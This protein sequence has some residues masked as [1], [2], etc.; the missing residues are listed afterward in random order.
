[1]ILL[2]LHSFFDGRK[3]RACI[4]ILV[5]PKDWAHDHEPSPSPLP[6]HFWSP[7][8]PLCPLLSPFCYQS[9]LPPPSY[10]TSPRFERLH[11]ANTLHIFNIN[12]PHSH[13]RTI[14]QRIDKIQWQNDCRIGFA[15][16]VIL[17]V[18]FKILQMGID[19]SLF[20]WPLHS[21]RF[22]AVSRLSPSLLPFA[23]ELPLFQ[24]IPYS[25]VM[26]ELMTYEHQQKQEPY[27]I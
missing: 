20:H 26:V 13:F 15:Y 3:C 9:P 1:M 21:I 2:P 18:S 8:F 17:F 6:L 4:H 27:W 16:T 10:P 25:T 22:F 12:I 7:I 23:T 14:L 24:S 11:F 5:H 19:V